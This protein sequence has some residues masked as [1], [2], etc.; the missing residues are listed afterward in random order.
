MQPT[1]VHHVRQ[2]ISDYGTTRSYT[3]L[4]EAG[5][6]L[7]EEVLTYL[8]LDHDARAVAA[9]L[10]DR[11]EAAQPVVLLYHDGLAFLRAFLGCLYAG[12]IAVPAPLPHDERSAHRVAG[13]VSDSGAELVL[14]TGDVRPLLETALSAAVVATDGPLGDPGEWRMPDI[15]PETI[16]FL[17]YTSGSTGDP[18]GVVVTHRNLMHN[19]AAITAIGF[20]D[21][22]VAVSWIPHFHDM[23]LIG[24]L[25]GSLYIGADLVFM[26]PTTFLKHPVRW[27]RAIGDYRATL[28]AAPNFAYDLI[29]R[30]VT[31]EQL[32]E[33]DLTTLEIAMSGAE[34][35]REKT[36]AA[37]TE[38]LAPAGLRPTALLPAYGLA[39]VTLL[40]AVG[41]IDA[42]PVYLDVGREARLVGCGRPAHGLDIRIIDPDTRRQLPEDTVGEIWIGGGSVAAGYWNRPE[43]SRETF[44]AYLGADGPFLRTGDLGLLHGGELFVTGRRKDLLIVN[45]RN[46][47]PQDVEEL[48]RGLHPALGAAGV[49][50]SVDAGGRERL[51]VVQGVKTARQGATTLAE[52]ASAI[53]IAVARGFDVA[54]PNVVLVEPHSVPRTTSGKVQRSAAREAFSAHRV[55]GVLHDDLEPA[56]R[57]AM[58]A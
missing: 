58:T 9:W 26:A 47:Y 15:G 39:E 4:H 10:A 43:E 57:R 36:I 27:L 16:A 25:L 53:K 40:A 24:M 54:A 49:A 8:E 51:V 20:D 55:E 13:I 46:L 28:T 32:A 2:Q 33:L 23:G 17:Q 11:P 44:E 3:Y 50:V 21:E 6:E 30:R 7:R 29:A 41:S 14:T 12:V 1:Y 31:D 19:E 37:V 52:L 35:I 22:S 42:E 18:K 5:R 56:L 34:P 38:R 48:V 45:G